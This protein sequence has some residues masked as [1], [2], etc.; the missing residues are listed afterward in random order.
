MENFFEKFMQYLGQQAPVLQAARLNSPS[1][2]HVL[3][4]K[5][6]EEKKKLAKTYMQQELMNNATYT[7]GPQYQFMR[8]FGPATVPI[9]NLSN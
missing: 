3:D 4:A 7:F 1:V 5:G 2:L 9:L 8:L 6:P